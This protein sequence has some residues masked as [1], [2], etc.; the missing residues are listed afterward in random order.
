MPLHYGRHTYRPDGDLRS[1]SLW[2]SAGA[3]V[4]HRAID[5]QDR[6]VTDRHLFRLDIP[7]PEPT[8]SVERI[9]LST[10]HSEVQILVAAAASL[11]H[12]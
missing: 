11:E 3:L 6:P 2:H 4:I 12:P 9:E 5:G 8:K 1:R 10:V 7:S